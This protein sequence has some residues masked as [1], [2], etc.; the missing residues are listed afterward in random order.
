MLIDVE[1]RGGG[2]GG[3]VDVVRLLDGGRL[4]LRLR[5]V[6]PVAGRRAVVGGVRVVAGGLRLEDDLP[7]AVG[8]DGR[9]LVLGPGGPGLGHGSPRGL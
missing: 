4:S 3:A 7:L 8:L 1:R 6:P 9:P 5:P 2:D